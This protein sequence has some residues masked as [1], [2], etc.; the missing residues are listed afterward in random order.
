MLKIKVAGT[1]LHVELVISCKSN[2]LV[3]VGREI[4]SFAANQT[5]L[6][7]TGQKVALVVSCN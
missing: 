6:A 3:Q 7:G 2:W 1:D 4:L 5:K